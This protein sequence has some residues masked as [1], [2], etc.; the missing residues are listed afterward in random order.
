MNKIK[1][2]KKCSWVCVCGG[3]CCCCAGSAHRE[4]TIIRHCWWMR[5]CLFIGPRSGWAG[6]GGVV[7]VE[8]DE[9]LV[10]VVV[11]VSAAWVPDGTARG[12]AAAIYFFSFSFS[13]RHKTSDVEPTT[14]KREGV[15][16]T[17]LLGRWGCDWEETKKQ[18]ISKMYGC[19]T[20]SGYHSN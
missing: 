19:K 10:V 6:E 18:K 1:T 3:C 4:S 7:A 9:A 11:V 17:K 5:Y 20:Y 13:L 2:Y 15:W 8:R 16:G 14:K 12:S